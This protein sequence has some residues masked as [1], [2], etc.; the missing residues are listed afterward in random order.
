MKV[1]FT[2]DTLANG[3]TEKSTLDIIRHFSKDTDARVVT[4]YPG[5]DLRQEYVQA[6]IPLIDLHLTGKRSFTTGIRKLITLIRQEKPDLVVSSI[7]RANLISRIACYLTKTPLIGTFVNDSYGEIRVREFKDKGQYGR[8]RFFWLLDRWTSGI[9]RFWISNAASIARSNAKALHLRKKNITVIYRGRDTSQFPVWTPPTGS[10]FRFVFI[11]RLLQRKGLAEMLEAYQ[12][13]RSAHPDVHLDIYGNGLFRKKMEEMIVQLG[14]A[15]KVTL[16]GTVPGGWKKI[17]GG[18]CFLFPSWYEGFSGSLVEAM[19]AGIPII[20][21]D[22]PMNRE[23]VDS[24]TALIFPMKDKAALAACMEKMILEYPSMA[25]MGKRAR[26]V[27]TGR[28]EIRTIAGQYESFLHKVVG[29]S[30]KESDLLSATN[31][32]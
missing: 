16:H 6:G 5:D 23:A 26:Q 17:Y 31:D 21:S 1:L 22:I 12:Q 20:A 30:V 24:S 25:E 10:T 9:P 28:Y 14:I 27:A 4:F 13:V 8:F 2:L 7:L 32:A 11:G 18:H 15:D 3:G 29:Q 19:I